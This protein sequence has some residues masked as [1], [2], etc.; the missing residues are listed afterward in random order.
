MALKAGDRQL[1]GPA[2][3]R[4]GVVREYTPEGK[5]VWEAKTPNMPFTA[6]R[7]DDG[8]TLIGCTLGNPVIED[9]PKRQDASGR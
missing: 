5:V 4:T 2:T 7:L 3:A 6:I 1:P 8:N 9:R